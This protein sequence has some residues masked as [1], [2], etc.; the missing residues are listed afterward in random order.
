MPQQPTV[1]VW[2]S[3]STM[4]AVYGIYAMFT[5]ALFYME[6]RTHAN[7]KAAPKPDHVYFRRVYSAVWVA[8]FVLMAGTVSYWIY[9]NVPRRGPVYVS[10]I[11]RNLREQ[12]VKPQRAEDPPLVVQR[13]GASSP[14]TKLYFSRA[15]E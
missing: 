3:V 9:V 1:E 8:I 6:R 15:G 10:G 7:L 2:S 5:I 13:I 12:N 11:I 4:L 14:E